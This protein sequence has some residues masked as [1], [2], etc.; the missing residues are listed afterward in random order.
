MSATNLD[1]DAGS[2]SSADPEALRSVAGA[3]VE[4]ERDI[5][6][7]NKERSL[8]ARANNMLAVGVFALLGVG[9]LFYYYTATVSH[10]N[11]ARA[12]V[13]A[14][15]A[16]KA[17]G[18]MKLPPLGAI[19]SPQLPAAAATATETGTTGAAQVLG[20][21][22]PL[23]AA[24]FDTGTS[25]GY[26]GGNPSGQ[27]PKSPEALALER[28][29]TPS[30]FLHPSADPGASAAHPVADDAA[31]LAAA[32]LP[33]APS[34]STASNGPLD[35]YLKP[36]AT[37]STSAQLLATRRFVIPKG[38]FVDCTLETAISSELPGLATCVTAFDV[39]GAD[40]KVV[41]IERGSKLVGE[42]KG[43][44]AQGLSR[45][46]ILW[47][48]ARTPTGVVV[49]LAS[50]GG[51]ELGRAGVTGHVDT[52]FWARF[53]AAIMVSIIDGAVQGVTA[54]QE[55]RGS[56]VVVTPQGGQQVMEDV[57]RGTI[58]I[59]P[60][61]NINQGTRIQV[62]V[63]RDVDFRSVYELKASANGG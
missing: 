3:S 12:K 25:G 30:V 39:F 10:R 41:L 1:A 15:R 48:E 40:G 17:S 29:L 6:S 35:G 23:G 37:A 38:N 22:P 63:A 36:T 47:T 14:E 46:F 60:T 19:E 13:E 4:G 55:S 50:P 58:N 57:L 8:Q 9:F 26:G 32:G 53:G 7:V 31:V 2:A 54:S 33:A 27:P 52:H 16:S 21:P 51:D 28:K 20:A 62:I 59:P 5:P 44:V 42:S 24:A 49:Q 11:Q 18:E 34:S 61:V 43:Q 45:V 56:G